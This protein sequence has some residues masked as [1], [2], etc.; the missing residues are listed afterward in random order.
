[1]AEITVRDD[2]VTLDEPVLVEGLPG[3]G[4]VG[5]IAVDHVVEHLDM[6]YYA[7]VDCDG[8]PRVS[9]YAEGSRGVRPPVRL[10]AS[11][12]HDLVALQ[13]H[14][15]V[16]REATTDFADCITGWVE[17]H[18]GTAM[19]LSGLPQQDQNVE[20]V[21]DMYG[22]ATGSAAGVL[23]EN[24][25]GTPPEDGVVGGPTGALLNRAADR[26]VDSVGLVVESNAQFPD[27]AAARVLIVHGINAIAGTDVETEQLVEDAEKIQEQRKR[28]AQRM[29]QAEE[30]ESSQAQPLQMFQ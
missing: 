6:T 28:L 9:V 16:S 25:I 4:L 20:E 22:V 1:M 14:V 3:V 21:P 11:E 24:D 27:P 12:E 8:L 19:Y 18:D 13:S 26:D 7:D 10:Y 5:K 29:Q 15:P 23:D 2:D 30:A 17:E